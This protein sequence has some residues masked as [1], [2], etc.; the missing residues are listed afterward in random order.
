[1]KKIPLIIE[2]G[3]DAKLWGRINYDNNL[4]T[5]YANSIPALERK[6]KKLLKDFHAVSEVVEF[7]HLYGVSVFFE[8]FNFLKQTKIAELAGINSSLLRQYATGIKHPSPEQA[9]KIEIAVHKLAKD[10]ESVSLYAE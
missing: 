4:V 9:K 6:M 3:E 1:M 8:N 2:R 10:L 7:E 5:D